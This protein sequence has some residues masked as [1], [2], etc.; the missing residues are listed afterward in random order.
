MTVQYLA[1]FKPI[2][3]ICPGTV[4]LFSF[5]WLTADALQANRSVSEFAHISSLTFA[6]L[7]NHNQPI[8][9]SE[10]NHIPALRIDV[11]VFTVGFVTNE[12]V[13]G[14]SYSTHNRSVPV[15]N[16]TLCASIHSQTGKSDQNCL[17][18]Y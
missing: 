11:Y 1:P 16:E 6:L 3:T 9:H 14:K 7:F 10:M 15:N 4:S 18:L 13:L 17:S 8:M 2:S 12:T 5:L